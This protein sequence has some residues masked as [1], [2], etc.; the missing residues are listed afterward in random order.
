MY[1]DLDGDNQITAKDQVN[2]GTTDPK[3]YLWYRFE[4][5]IQEVQFEYIRKWCP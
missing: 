4:C 3:T 2:I 5:T 1:K